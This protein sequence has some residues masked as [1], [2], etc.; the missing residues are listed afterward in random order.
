V[1]PLS[2]SA[3]AGIQ[4]LSAALRQFM[5]YLL[6]AVMAALVT[7]AVCGSCGQG[8]RAAWA[9][10]GPPGRR[11]GTADGPDGVRREVARGIRE[12]ER[13]LTA[14]SEPR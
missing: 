10:V 3:Y 13:Y 9:R 8:A 11:D 1:L 7:G 4:V 2:A 6:W 14:Q 12:I 5:S